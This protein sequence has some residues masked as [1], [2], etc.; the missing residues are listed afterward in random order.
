MTADARTSRNIGRTVGIL[1]VLIVAIVATFVY[2]MVK[3][4][5]LSADALRANNTFVFER[6]RDIGDFSLQDDT[7]K[8]FTPAQLQGRWS[9]LFFGFTFCPDVCPT[10][11]ALLNQFYGKLQPQLA[12]DTQ[13]I[14]VS[15]DPGRDD[16]AKLHQYVGYFNPA[17]RGVTGEFLA[18]QKFAT[19]LNAPFSKVPGGGENYQVAHSGSVAIVDTNGHYIGFFKEPL[20]LEKML[21]SY[22]SIRLSHR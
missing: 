19:S 22:E 10:T 14:M 20:D 4:R 16:A 1:V 2:S 12:R 11:M 17:F 8:P 18:L 9:L 3:P 21:R 13:V 15:V 5:A 6:P 7:G